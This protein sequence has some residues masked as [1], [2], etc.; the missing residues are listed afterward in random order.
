M[1]MKAYIFDFD[2]TLVDSMPTW[3]LKMIRILEHYGV[4]YPK[5]VIRR[6]TPLGDIGTAKYFREELG[7]PATEE[8]LYAQMDAY[9]LPKYRDEIPIKAGVEAYLRGLKARG[10][11]LHVLTASPHKMVDPC[12]K[13]LGIFDL[14]ENVWSSDD[15]GMTKSQPE[16]YKEAAKRIGVSVEEAMFFDDNI[17]ALQTAKA[18]GMHTVGVY[19][20]TGEDFMQQMKE[21]AERYIMTFEEMELSL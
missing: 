17:G 16:I 14:F 10:A 12:L 19:D 3:S 8:E 7:V 6:I 2:G 20:P 9:A 13:R 18:A 15:F 4:S 21:T 5:D 1:V 11:S